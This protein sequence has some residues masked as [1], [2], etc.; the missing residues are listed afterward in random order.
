MTSWPG[1]GASSGERSIG[2]TG[3]LDPRA[4]GL[5]PLVLGRATRLASLVGGGDKT[6]DATIR[7]GFATDTDDADGHAA[8]REP[9]GTCPACG[10]GR[11]GAGAISSARSTNCRRI[12]RPRKCRATARTTS[13]ARRGPVDLKPVPVTVLALEGL[14][15]EGDRV[16]VRVTSTSG[17]YVRSLARDLGA[18]LGCGGHLRRAPADPQ[19]GL[20]RRRTPCRS[21]EAERLG[22]AVADRLVSPAEALPD[23][24]SVRLTDAGLNRAVHG[25]PL[26]PEH[27]EGRWIPAAGVAPGPVRVLAGDGRLVALAHAARRRFASGRR[28]RIT[29]DP[30][31]RRA[32]RSL[33][34]GGPVTHPA[35]S[36]S[37]VEGT[38]VLT[39]ERKTE[40]IGV[41]R[42]HDAD[43]GSPEVQVALLSERINYLTEHFKTHVKDHHSRRGLLKL[44][45]QRRRLLDYL[46][47]K[48]ADR[49]AS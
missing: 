43:T 18:A 44:V 7:L 6:Y 3:T 48:D 47:R 32:W 9:S 40:V 46:K 33:Y 49:Y 14:D 13:P 12:T 17:F 16:R 19:R 21:D 1:C 15:V 28:P 29:S 31:G 20:R 5:L 30:C 34:D 2:H 45:G 11:G 25:N 41:Y 8:R 23:L 26:G 37:F 35:R 10:G 39:N 38:N 42:T 27:L 22:R 4:T 36:G 24:P